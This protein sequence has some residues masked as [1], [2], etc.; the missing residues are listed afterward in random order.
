MK[1]VSISDESEQKYLGED[2]VVQEKAADVTVTNAMTE[3]QYR[4]INRLSY[5]AVKKFL[6]DR[7]EYYQAYELRT[8]PIDKSSADMKHGAL[9]ETYLWTE[10]SFS[11]KFV[12]A[13]HPK[14]V[15]HMGELV[16]ELFRLTKESLSPAGTITKA[17]NELLEEAY[18]KVAFDGSG[19]QIKLKS[20]KL[21]DILLGYEGSD[22]QRYYDQMLQ[23]PGKFLVDLKEISYAK[24]CVAQ[25]REHW[26]TTQL[27]NLK[28]SGRYAV[29]HQLPVLYEYL[30][31]PFKSMLDMVVVDHQMKR[32]LI[33]DLKTTFSVEDFNFTYRK[34]RY[35]IQAY[36][37]Y[38]AIQSWAA[39]MGLEG[40]MVTPM[41]FI[42][43]DAKAQVAP[44]IYSVKKPNMLNAR[45]G[46]SYKS[47][48]YVGVAE[49]VS[50]LKWHR[51]TGIW[52]MSKWIFENKGMVSLKTYEDAK[53]E[54]EQHDPIS[55]A[56]FG[57]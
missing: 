47:I 57:N 43:A 41:K 23:T 20:K 35:Y 19:T 53:G 7:Q 46:F 4:A 28:S 2:I 36:L 54:M 18:A 9:V 17:F 56:G 48:S 1:M 52:D 3:R 27:V 10:E 37:Y 34:Y 12:E 14:P 21:G 33:Y 5:S 24:K 11:E 40:Y 29:Y 44:L 6:D 15:G 42:V 39:Q 49:A 30:Q 38:R 22:F 26:V 55:G 8:K 31:T 45:N 50:S 51:T 32:I 13:T 25:L 16:D